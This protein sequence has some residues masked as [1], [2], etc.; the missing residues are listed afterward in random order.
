[1]LVV[2]GPAIVISLQTA[3]KIEIPQMLLK[4]FVDV[5]AMIS[6][7]V[8][9]HGSRLNHAKTKISQKRIHGFDLCLLY[10]LQLVARDKINIF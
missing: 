7:W 2:K 6:E 9:I 4:N 3:Y 1:M 8:D 5:F 10:S